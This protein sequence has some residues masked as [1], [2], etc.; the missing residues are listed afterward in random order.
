MIELEVT[1]RV[2]KSMAET[3][4]LAEEMAESAEPAMLAAGV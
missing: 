4:V 3:L 2:Q 1:N